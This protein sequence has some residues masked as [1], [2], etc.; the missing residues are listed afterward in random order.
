MH[1]HALLFLI[2]SFV[3]NLLFRISRFSCQITNLK[4]RLFRSQTSFPTSV[5]FPY[6]ES[7]RTFINKMK[8][9]GIIHYMDKKIRGNYEKGSNYINNGDTTQ[10]L[11]NHIY[12]IL[13]IL[14]VAMVVALLVFGLEILFHA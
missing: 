10:V 13:S 6:H 1:S 8:S 2:H 3:L 14:A 9:A 5:L 4:H 7:F 11:F 12:I